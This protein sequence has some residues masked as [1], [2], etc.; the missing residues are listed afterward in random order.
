MTLTWYFV[1][2]KSLIFCLSSS[3]KSWYED[4][5]DDEL[6]SIL[7]VCPSVFL[8]L[9]TGVQGHRNVRKILTVYIILKE[10]REIS[11]PHMLV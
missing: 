5:L 9:S 7:T 3:G 4:L 8:I 1:M 6:K 2:G 10:F 11:L